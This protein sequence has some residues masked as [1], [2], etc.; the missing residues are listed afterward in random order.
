M[1]CGETIDTS[2]ELATHIPMCSKSERGIFCVALSR[3]IVAQKFVKNCGP[4]ILN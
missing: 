3:S 1:G 4:D 2:P